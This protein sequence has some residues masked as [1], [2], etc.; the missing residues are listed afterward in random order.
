MPEREVYP[1]AP[2]RLVTAEYR[3]PLSPVLS[4]G[5][6]L[7]L[8]AS[9]LGSTLPIIE[10]AS[11]LQLTLGPN[12]SPPTVTTGYRLLTR[13]RMT[14]ITVSPSRLAIETTSYR[15]WKEFRDDFVLVR[16]PSAR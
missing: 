12:L 9:A 4:R 6:L 2:L 5:D 3:F 16:A 7:P 11:E 14:A 1:S 15:H 10:P 8:V 13:D